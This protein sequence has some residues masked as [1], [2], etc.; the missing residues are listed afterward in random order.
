MHPKNIHNSPYDFDA[1]IKSNKKLESHI[2]INPYGNKSIDF[3]VNE[4]VLQLNRAILIHHYNLLDWDI[5]KDYLCPP[6]PGRADYI[7]YI[8]DLLFENDIK[9]EITG[10]D[11]G[12]G[13]NCI[14]PLLGAQLYQW[15]MVGA[16]I[17]PMAISTAKNNVNLTPCLKDNI[18]IRHQ[19]NNANIFD[20]IIQ[21]GEY[22]HFSMCNPP[23]HS[24]EEE[25]TKGTLRKL[26]NVS[27]TNSKATSLTLNFGGQANELWCNGGEALFIKRMIKQS[28][29][30]KNQVNWFTSLVSKKDN[31]PKIYKQLHKAKAIHKTI[32]MSQGHKKSRFVAWKFE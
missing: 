18:E 31:L 9:D 13:A 27:S 20:G 16:D 6:I 7:H 10:L 8:A 28:I 25:A 23:F 15:K 22:Y 1:L 2:C 30:Y 14:Y 4:A 32:E 11:I 3:S 12:V 19:T 29:N 21:K 17:N 24:S 26:N 5:P